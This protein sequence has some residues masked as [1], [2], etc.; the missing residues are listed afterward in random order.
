MINIKKSDWADRSPRSASLINSKS[1]HRHQFL[2]T[3]IVL[4]LAS[5]F[6][7]ASESF[8][9]GHQVAPMPKQFKAGDYDVTHVGT[10][11]I[12]ADNCDRNH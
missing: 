7:G 11:V 2:T 3:S 8:T 9:Q 10:T 4:L 6:A 1:M 12:I 5:P